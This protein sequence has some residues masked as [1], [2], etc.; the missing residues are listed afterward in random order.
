MKGEFLLEIGSE[1]IPARAMDKALNDLGAGFEEFLTKS[2]LEFDQVRTLGTA[3]R[4]A[5]PC[6]ARRCTSA[7]ERSP[8]AQPERPP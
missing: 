6:S 1:E 7:S 2:G 8:L 4:F 3:R 5:P